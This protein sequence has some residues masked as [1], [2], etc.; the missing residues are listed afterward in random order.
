[1]NNQKLYL[2]QNVLVE[3]LFNQWYA[4]PHLIP[5]A[6]GA[7]YVANLHLN[8]MRSYIKG[9]QIH[10]AAVKN[11]AMLGGPFVDYEGKRV[12]EIK[13]LLD[14]T[15]KEQAPMVEFSDAVKNLDEMLKR[16]A[17]GYALEPLYEKVPSILKG[18]V[19]LTYDLNNHP[20][21]RFLEGLLYESP[22]YNTSS[23]S[24]SL[25]L[26]TQDYRP[27]VL[28]TPRLADDSHLQL[29][30]PFHDEV[31]DDLCRMRDEPQSFEDLRE[32]LGVDPENEERLRSFLTS[33]RNG[34]AGSVT[35]Y[36]GEGVRIRYFG[37]A[38]LLLEARGVSMLTD[39]SVS[40]EYESD[41][42]RYTFSDLPKT[43]DYV[44]IT[45]VHQDH[46]LLETLLQLRHK[47]KNI[48]IPRSGGGSLADPSLKMI[49]TRLGFKSV[50]E[51]DEMEEE[52]I[53]SGTI[54]CLPFLGEHADLNIKSKAA[55]LIQLAGH[56]VV[57]AADSSNIEPQL[58]AHIRRVV[59]RV[60]VIF[61]GME[62]DGAPLSWV[63]GPLLTQ[64]LDRKMDHSRKLSGSNFVKAFDLI[65][66]L[67][68]QQVYVYA[69]GQEPWLNHIMSLQYSDS[70]PQIMESN[71]LIEE[72][73]KRGVIAE[74]LFGRRE[75]FL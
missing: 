20:S 46:L 7:M 53:E 48:V 3:P 42:P 75:M 6:S 10:A 25:S 18:Y 55:Y 50:I 67:E 21:I 32:R 66:Q 51:L 34:N 63:Y 60:E 35:G 74:R 73:H 44:L 62:C 59:G 9:P 64:P 5:P 38:S 8:I 45:H 72:C 56:S 71:R 27:F 57:C 33:G 29:G 36:D 12:D 14:K 31:I 4:W 16:E 13:A 47:I 70:S 49:L 37:H 69:M 61:L 43:L 19:E 26:V 11:P 24:I 23:Q 28:S 39:P 41:I 40:Y 17:K 54:T 22:Y 58:Y 1:M 30:I 68:C 65:S 52:E 2:K 15:G